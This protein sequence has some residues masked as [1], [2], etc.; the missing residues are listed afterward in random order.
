[1]VNQ[2]NIVV[3]LILSIVTCGIYGLYWIVKVTDDSIALSE[4]K[5]TQGITVLFLTIIT[6]GIYGIFWAYAINKRLNK[7]EQKK[8]I[9]SKNHGILYIIFYILGVVITLALIQSRI[10]KI[11]VFSESAPMGEG[12]DLSF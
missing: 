11:I 7:I 12:N 1:M 5:G 8:E 10:N 3:S 4:E 9:T 2:K 6:I